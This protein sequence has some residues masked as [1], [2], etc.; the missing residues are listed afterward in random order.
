MT[1]I[2][3]LG[4]IPKEK[5]GKPIVF[6]Q[7]LTTDLEIIENISTYTPEDFEVIE[8]ICKDYNSNKHNSYDL[9]F[10]YDKDRSEGYLFLGQFNDGIV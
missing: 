10:A 2:I 8:L 4:D 7:F 1:K 9:M 3:I 6:K 5:K